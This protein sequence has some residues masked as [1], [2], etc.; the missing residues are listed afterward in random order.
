MDASQTTDP[1]FEITPE[2]QQYIDGLVEQLS[3]LDIAIRQ[4]GIFKIMYKGVRERV[5]VELALQKLI[6]KTDIRYYKAF[7]K[8]EG[9]PNSCYAEIIALARQGKLL[10]DIAHTQW[11]FEAVDRA[12]QGGSLANELFHILDAKTMAA[13]QMLSCRFTLARNHGV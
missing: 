8:P 13:F 11:L 1:G 6:G 2:D 10:D 3:S 12:L 4:K 5:A 9:D 7:S